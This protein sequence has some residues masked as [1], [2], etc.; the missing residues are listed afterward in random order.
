MI[1]NLFDSNTS[2]FVFIASPLKNWNLDEIAFYNEKG[3]WKYSLSGKV[4]EQEE[5]EKCEVSQFTVPKQFSGVTSKV[6]KTNS[7]FRPNT[8]NKPKWNISSAFRAIS[9]SG[10]EI[11]KQNTSNEP[12]VIK[13]GMLKNKVF[14]RSNTSNSNN[15][16]TS[17][18]AN[19]NT[20]TGSRRYRNKKWLE[21]PCTEEF[22]VIN[23][24]RIVY[25]HRFERLRFNSCIINCSFVDVFEMRTEIIEAIRMHFSENKTKRLTYQLKFRRDGFYLET[26][27]KK[28]MM[29]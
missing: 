18:S 27:R 4:V 1:R 9:R 6:A 8:S 7:T 19:S 15:S 23:D 11:L 29:L 14:Q 21:P 25:D 5:E 22:G 28:K 26:K 24:Q 12:Q 16:N 3:E 20:S 13:S 17:S 2:K 10:I